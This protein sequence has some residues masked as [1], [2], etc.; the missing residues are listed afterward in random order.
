L[1]FFL[2]LGPTSTAAVSSRSRK[3]RITNR[4]QAGILEEDEAEQ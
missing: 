2:F 4:C 1:L 3:L